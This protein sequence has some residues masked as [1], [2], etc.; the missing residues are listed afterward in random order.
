[1]TGYLGEC[2]VWIRMPV[3][4]D[5]GNGKMRVRVVPACKYECCR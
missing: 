2:S 3:P 4:V 5:Y 1:M